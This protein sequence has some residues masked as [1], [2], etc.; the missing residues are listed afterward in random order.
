MA[1][2]VT[3]AH[4]VLVSHFGLLVDIKLWPLL[5]YT[6]FTHNVMK[7]LKGIFL[8]TGT[9][10]VGLRKALYTSPPTNLFIVT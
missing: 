10:F 4:Q 8:Y 7:I 5:V 9:H 6:W 2:S 3:A 1:L